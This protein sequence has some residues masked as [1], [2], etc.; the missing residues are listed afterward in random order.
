M[1]SH[2]AN[3]VAERT[4]KL[5][6]EDEYGFITYYYLVNEVA[7]LMIEDIYVSPEHRRKGVASAMAD[8]L[9]EKAKELGYTKCWGQVCPA[10]KNSTE[11]MKVM[12]AWGL[13]IHSFSNNVIFLCKDI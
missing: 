13:N 12:L 10:A 4:N 2:Y 9:V 6:Y 1:P 3:Y 11:S 7:G 5:I 8:K